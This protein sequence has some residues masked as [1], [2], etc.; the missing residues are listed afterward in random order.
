[1]PRPP[2]DNGATIDELLSDIRDKSFASMADVQ[3][4]LERRVNAYNSQPQEELGGL[5]PNE[6]QALL[7]SDWSTKG[8]LIVSDTLSADDVRGADILH[9][10]VALLTALRDEGPAKTT[11]LGNLSREFVGR[12]LPRFRWRPGYIEHVREMNKV[13]DEPDVGPLM[14][15]RNLLELAR[16]IHKRKG[17]RI[18]PAGRVLLDEARRGELFALLFRTFFRELSLAWVEHWDGDAGLQQ[19]IAFTFWKLR[20]ETE[21]WASPDHLARVAWLD[22]AK[23]PVPEPWAN[24]STD[25]RGG[26]F[27]RRV[28]EP[29]VWFGLLESRDVPAA[30]KWQRPIEVRKTPLYDR[31]LRFDFAAR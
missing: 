12:M 27:R 11:K 19:T 13:I 10:A 26:R 31:L 7:D 15:L 21:S 17:F 29:L 4:H 23:E 1:M 14:I 6:M 3:R 30:E 22:T 9:N 5:S 2:D 18:S 16:L 24:L 8:P 25:F 20:T 28:L